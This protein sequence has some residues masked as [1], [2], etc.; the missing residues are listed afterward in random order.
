ML[1]ACSVNLETWLL[2]VSWLIEV[3]M[4]VGNGKRFGEAV[5]PLEE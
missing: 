3:G 2:R 1:D 5:I 4:K